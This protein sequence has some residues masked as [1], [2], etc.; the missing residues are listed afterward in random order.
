MLFILLWHL[1]SRCWAEVGHQVVHCDTAQLSADGWWRDGPV[2]A[3]SILTRN[4]DDKLSTFYRE[5]FFRPLYL[6][7]LLV[8]RGYNVIMY[9]V[10]LALIVAL[11]ASNVATLS[12]HI[13]INPADSTHHQSSG[14]RILSRWYW[15]TQKVP[16]VSRRMRLIAKIWSHFPHPLLTIQLLSRY[17]RYF[18][19]IRFISPSFSFVIADGIFRLIH[20]V[21][22]MQK[23]N[24]KMMHGCNHL[25]AFYFSSPGNIDGNWIGYR[26]DS[27]ETI[28]L[29][30]QGLDDFNFI[31]DIGAML[32]VGREAA[33]CWS[34]F[35]ELVWGGRSSELEAGERL[36]LVTTQEHGH[37]HLGG[38]EAR[39]ARP[40]QHLQ[41]E[42]VLMNRYLSDE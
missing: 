31:V 33:T 26:K 42:E 9:S 37:P 15:G 3:V 27:I 35:G 22:C 23:M 32:G 6:D 40:G 41:G 25:L 5:S 21:T 39:R 24:H 2:T 29:N 38:Q 8:V 18:R 28:W 36:E 17:C 12:L 16:P 7:C 13:S 4:Y 34:Q 30:P 14:L 11:R 10:T 20:P 1:A 19:Y